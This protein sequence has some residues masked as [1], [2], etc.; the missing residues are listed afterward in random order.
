MFDDCNIFN[1]FGIKISCLYKNIANKTIINQQ[2][3]KRPV[4]NPFK[5]LNNLFSTLYI[6][7][8]NLSSEKFFKRAILQ[9]SD[10]SKE[11]FFGISL[12]LPYLKYF[13]NAMHIRCD[14]FEIAFFTSW[15]RFR[16]K[17]KATIIRINIINSQ[18]VIVE[19]PEVFFE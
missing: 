2:N 10:S 6:L 15:S 16:S 8:L 11:R 12:Y 7:S 9:K 13:F 4:Q 1:N 19:Y 3:F 18:R 17:L 5:N 14:I